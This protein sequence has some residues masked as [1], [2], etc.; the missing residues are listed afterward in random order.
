MT[1]QTAWAMWCMENDVDP[2][3]NFMDMPVE[4]RLAVM[5]R[6]TK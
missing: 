4:I 1:L 2:A 3:T 6:V 5:Q